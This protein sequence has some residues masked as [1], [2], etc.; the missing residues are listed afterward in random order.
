MTTPNNKSWE[1]KEKFLD[2]PVNSLGLKLGDMILHNGEVIRDIPE[3]IDALDSLL[4]QDRKAER[5]RVLG[6][7]V[8]LIESMVEDDLQH[9]SRAADGGLMA[10]LIDSGSVFASEVTTQLKKKY[11]L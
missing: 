5:E 11:N 8:Q 10:H 9:R 1:E 7:V 4:E 2:S 6:E 3:F